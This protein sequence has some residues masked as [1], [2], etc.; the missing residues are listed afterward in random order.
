MKK[1]LFIGLVSLCLSFAIVA[2]EK[3]NAPDQNNE[4][5][6]TE[7][8]D[9][10]ETPAPKAEAGFTYEADGLTVTFTNTS[11]NA[12]RYAW[13]FGDDESSTEANPVYTYMVSGAY[14]VSLRAYA[15]DGTFDT[16]KEQINVVGKAEVLFT[17]TA[18]FGYLVNFDASASQNV[19]SEGITWDFG[20][21]SEPGTG[22]QT[23]HE[24]P[25]NGTYDVTLTMKDLAGNDVSKTLQVTV[26]GDF[27]V[28]KG[29]DFEAEDAQYWFSDNFFQ[30]TKNYPVEYEFGVTA[31]KPTDGV[32]ACLAIKQWVPLGDDEYVAGSTR[33]F[34]YQ[35]I[36]IDIE[37]GQHYRVTASYKIG[38]S[39]ADGVIAVRYYFAK[40]GVN[41]GDSGHPDFHGGAKILNR[42][43]YYAE[44]GET[45][46][47]KDETVVKDIYIAED[48]AYTG[49]AYF[50]VDFYLNEAQMPGDYYMDN[51]KVE[52]VPAE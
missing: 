49:K 9:E 5:P 30:N 15:E 24:Y 8:E 51:L 31:D 14:E 23:S 4:K 21:S 37:A 11:K 40:D 10:P 19:G 3:E 28:I 17:T 45:L 20:D 6:N 1:T 46:A 36:L 12:V 18:G 48:L 50:A 44:A 16:H 2:C 41:R 33:G 43:V 38:E 32:G 29:G 52:L 47:A 13:D 39:V 25:A 35:P 34:L 26:V 22:M 27:N 7:K 42:D